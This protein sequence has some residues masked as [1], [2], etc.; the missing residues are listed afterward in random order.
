MTEREW[1]QP[2]AIISSD[3]CLKG[4]GAFLTAEGKFLHWEYPQSVRRKNLHINEL[5]CIMVV[6]AINT[7]GQKL[8]RKKILIHC[9]NEVTVRAINSGSSRNVILQE[10]LRE[11][12]RLQVVFHC[13]LRAQFIFGINNRI[14]DA[15]SR[16]H[17]HENIKGSLRSSLATSLQKRYKLARTVLTLFLKIFYV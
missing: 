6:V 8:A 7:W 17:T 4:G 11:L 1:S 14:S 10:C 16:W 12:H 15:L 9:D 5:E 13:E 3:S 2:D